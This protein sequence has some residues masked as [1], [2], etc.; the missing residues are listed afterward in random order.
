MKLNEALKKRLEYQREK[1]R[2]AED[3]AAAEKAAQRA[4]EKRMAKLL[5]MRVCADYDID[6][7]TLPMFEVVE[8]AKGEGRAQLCFYEGDEIVPKGA[9]Q[10]VNPISL[11]EDHSQPLVIRYL[12][13][14]K[15]PEWKAFHDTYA[16]NFH[17]FLMTFFDS[18][19]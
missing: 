8:E 9:V 19:R 15:E 2:E 5:H 13:H 7:D 1:Q 4:R 3:K 14:T 12:R 16:Q 18:L 6:P 17:N 10:L 11:Y